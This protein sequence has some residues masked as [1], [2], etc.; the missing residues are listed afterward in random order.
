M[1][2][3]SLFISVTFWKEALGPLWYHLL[4]P[5]RGSVYYCMHVH[6]SPSRRVLS[7]IQFKTHGLQRSINQKPVCATVGSAQYT[8]AIN[9][10]LFDKQVEK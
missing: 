9:S 1:V 6:S 2:V 10:Y 7:T 8:T 3:V 4:S 5:T